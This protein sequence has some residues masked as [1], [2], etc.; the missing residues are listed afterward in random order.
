MAPSEPL[1]AGSLVGSVMWDRVR[2]NPLPLAF[3]A[4]LLLALAILRRRRHGDD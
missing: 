1:D 4:G 2:K 3:V